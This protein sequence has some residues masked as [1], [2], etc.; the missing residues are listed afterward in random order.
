MKPEHAWAF[1]PNTFSSMAVKF[2]ETDDRS[3]IRIVSRRSPHLGV[4]IA[5]ALLAGSFAAICGTALVFAP[6]LSSDA[7]L[8]LAGGVVFALLFWIVMTSLTFTSTWRHAKK[9][10]WLE[11]DRAS[12]SFRVP[13]QNLEFVKFDDSRISIAM[14][15]GSTQLTRNANQNQTLLTQAQIGPVPNSA[16]SWIPLITR[17]SR[18]SA[19]MPAF[20]E[21][22]AAAGI[23]FAEVSMSPD[24][25]PSMQE[26]GRFRHDA[27]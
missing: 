21:F 1:T 2:E 22:A 19:T 14:L 11:Y 26:I 8:I 9:P 25:G 6:N 18:G 12:K 13:R 24:R 27:Y 7:R 5:Y 3:V 15:T 17:S 16:N 20:R 4:V 23:H 10:A